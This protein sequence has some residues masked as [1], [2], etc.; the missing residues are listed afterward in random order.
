MLYLHIYDDYN[1]GVCD[2][3]HHDS[4][5]SMISYL[6]QLGY[7]DVKGSFEYFG[8][9]TCAEYHVTLDPYATEILLRNK[10]IVSD[11]RYQMAILA[12]EA[13]QDI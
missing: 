4:Y 12:N 11:C 9:L 5:T 3:S 1:S 10:L 2:V 6:E 7:D 8:D 13:N